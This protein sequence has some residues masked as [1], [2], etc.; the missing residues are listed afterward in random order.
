M[1]KRSNCSARRVAPNGARPNASSPEA[2]VTLL[3]MIVVLAIMAIVAG[4]VVPNVIGRPDQARVSV[5]R[6]DLQSI[7]AALKIYRL[8][9]GTFPS[10]RDGLEELLKKPDGAASPN[11][12]SPSGYLDRVPLDPWGQPYV[13]RASS[14]GGF[15][16]VSL[17][18]DS[19]PGGEALD[20]DIVHVQD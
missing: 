12:A 6:T 14:R 2:G 9:T 15:E 5:A 10:T 4:L 18:A 3:E 17:G 13:Y 7:A 19:R 1:R 20:A 16:L 11:G 8:D